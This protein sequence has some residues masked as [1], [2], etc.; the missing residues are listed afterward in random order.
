MCQR[1][2]NE[3]ASACRLLYMQKLLDSHQLCW[4]KI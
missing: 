3:L 2:V 4:N 1:Y